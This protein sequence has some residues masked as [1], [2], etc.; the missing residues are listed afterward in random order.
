MTMVDEHDEG[1]PMSVREHHL[2][3][4]TAIHLDIKKLGRF[5]QVGH[6]ITGDR[7]RQSS[8]RGRRGGKSWGAGWE[9]V[10]VC[11]DDASRIAFSQVMPDERSKAPSP[12]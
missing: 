2:V 12:S 9:Y 5:Q 7:T 11:V 10:H 4:A 1:G 6:R 8:T 3:V